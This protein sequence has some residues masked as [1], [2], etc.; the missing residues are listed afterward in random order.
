V[1]VLLPSSI[2]VALNNRAPPTSS[3]LTLVI[4]VSVT[5][6]PGEPRLRG[7]DRRKL[8]AIGTWPQKEGRPRRWPR[9]ELAAGESAERRVAGALPIVSGV[10]SES[11]VARASATSA[12][13]N[14]YLASAGRASNGLPLLSTDWDISPT[15]VVKCGRPQVRATQPQCVRNAGAVA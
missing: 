2:F 9:A 3:A 4:S 1:T 8:L 15:C 14:R 11:A 6:V 5:P 10:Q 13:A 12:A 7:C